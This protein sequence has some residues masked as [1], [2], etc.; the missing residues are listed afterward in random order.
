MFLYRSFF[1][2]TSGSPRQKVIIS[3]V[4]QAK[5]T[6]AERLTNTPEK[7]S[8]SSGGSRNSGREVP[9]SARQE[10][11]GWPRPL[12]V[13]CDHLSVTVHGVYSAGKQPRSTSA[14]LFNSDSL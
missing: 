10:M 9:L 4:N 14:V 6:E 2:D 7:L 5:V 3:G 13:T 12:L 11:F 1:G 8:L